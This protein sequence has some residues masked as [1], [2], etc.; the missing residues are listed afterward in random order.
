LLLT[1]IVQTLA[2][3]LTRYGNAGEGTIGTAGNWSP[4]QA[5]ASGD[6][7]I[8]GGTNSLLPQLSS[9]LTVGSLNFASGAGAFT[10]G[11]AGA[12]TINTS[13]G[14]TNNSTS[15]E[16]INNAIILG[17]AQTWSA[18]SGNLVFGGNITNGGFL[19]TIVGSS[20]TNATGI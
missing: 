15:T 11:G 20:N 4:G 6:L 14:V 10:L 18:T 5:P 7:L 9:G 16:T 1:F 3:T 8:F 12:Y 17:I 2:A 19:P 13:A